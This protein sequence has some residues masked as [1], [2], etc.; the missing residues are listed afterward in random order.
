[1]AQCYRVACRRD[2]KLCHSLL[3]GSWPGFR[4]EE[5]QSRE[6]SFS[7]SDLSLP[8]PIFKAKL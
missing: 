7:S 3:L 8:S 1:M 4:V 5:D 6:D 2:R